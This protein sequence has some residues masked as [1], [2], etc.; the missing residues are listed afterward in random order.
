MKKAVGY[1]M[2]ALPFVAI[3]AFATV[4]ASFLV[5][6]GVFSIVAIIVGVVSVGIELISS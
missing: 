2:I 6:W 4:N 1:C 5:A 3:F